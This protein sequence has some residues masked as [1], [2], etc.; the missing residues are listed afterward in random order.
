LFPA[1]LGSGRITSQ[2]YPRDFMLIN[3]HRLAIT[4]S[5]VRG[6]DR[7]KRSTFSAPFAARNAD[8]AD[9]VVS[10]GEAVDETRS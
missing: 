2:H 5:A 9:R 1:D 4:R 7:Q 10:S 8:P 6:I 3:F